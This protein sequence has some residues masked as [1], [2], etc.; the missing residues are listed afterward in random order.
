MINGKRK[1]E[2]ILVEDIITKDFPNLKTESYTYIQEA[3][4]SKQTKV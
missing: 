1:L 4:S 3:E 2:E